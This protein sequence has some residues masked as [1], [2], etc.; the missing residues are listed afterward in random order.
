[1]TIGKRIGWT[2]TALVGVSIVLASVSL[3]GLSRAEASLNSLHGDTVPGMYYSQAM[4]AAL[5]EFRGNCWK[6][7][8]SSSKELMAA[9]EQKN[10]VLKRDMTEIL[11]KYEGFVSD[12]SDRRVWG[13]VKPALDRYLEAWSQVQVVSRTG[14]NVEAADLYMR[15]ANP[16]FLDLHRILE[17]RGAWN[18]NVNDRTMSAALAS[19]QKERVVTLTLALAAIAFGCFLAVIV[20]RGI[21]RELR[22]SIGKLAAGASQVASAASQVSSS[23]Q[24]LA[25]S[26]SEQAASLEQTSATSE[27]ISAMAMKNSENMHQAA[28]LAQQS[29]E[30]FQLTNRSLDGMVKAI[31]EIGDSSG[32]IS[33]I[34]KVI[35][36]IAFQT[37]ILAL[38]A[39]VEAARA[40]EAGMGFAVVADEVRSL[41][42]RCAQA[43]KETATLIEDSIHKSGEGKSKVDDVASAIHA[44]T[45]ESLSV[46]TLIDEVN[47]GSSEQSRGVQQISKAISQMERVTQM[48]AASAE[49]GASASE[50]LTAQS[51]AL[52]EIW[53]ELSQLVGVR[54]SELSPESPVS[55]AGCPWTPDSAVK[56]VNPTGLGQ[57]HERA[58]AVDHAD[59]EVL[60]GLQRFLAD[61]PGA[62]AAIEP[63]K[64][65]AGHGAVFHNGSRC[66][67]RGH[68]ECALHRGLD[69]GDIGK[70]E[71]PVDL[72]RFRIDW[73]DVAAAFRAVR[74]RPSG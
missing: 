61:G 29:Q 20:V 73:D 55:W 70:T 26:A 51:A 9:E 64:A 12:E 24:S 50:E 2:C 58:F 8:A 40:G 46:R 63:D 52:H 56:A 69:A 33:R 4:Q 5:F 59:A 67:G 71:G 13:Q 14:Q 30:K 6:H 39:A 16:L 62:D 32:K 53:I 38:N 23:S 21:T 42:H 49:E 43:A 11:R 15:T 74:R 18:R 72:G 35:D 68:D 57:K 1:M 28:A 54:S 22:D 17:D 66:G 45:A 37:N 47:Q 10:E 36:E 34:I 27:E 60:T 25:Q 3:F 41:A 44:I 65:D 48:T 7:I 31:G 19:A